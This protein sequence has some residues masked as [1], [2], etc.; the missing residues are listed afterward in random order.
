[1]FNKRGEFLKTLMRILLLFCSLAQVTYADS[2]FSQP[3]TD[4]WN[5]DTDPASYLF[6]V[7]DTEK[8]SPNGFQDGNYHITVNNA[9]SSLYGLNYFGRLTSEDSTRAKNIDLWLKTSFEFSSIETTFAPSDPQSNLETVS[10]QVLTGRLGAGPVLT[11]DLN[12][13]LKPFI[14]AEVWAFA[15]RTSNPQAVEFIGQGF[16]L[17]PMIGIN[18][19]IYGSLRGVLQLGYNHVLTSQ[20]ELFSDG[21]SLTFGL[22]AAL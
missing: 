14:G 7:A 18:S 15:Y 8:F 5:S 1:M 17:E 10:G 3:L 19:K 21:T 9:R 13:Y 4:Q 20:G 12:S 2:Q 6:M 22:G 16:M 11:Y